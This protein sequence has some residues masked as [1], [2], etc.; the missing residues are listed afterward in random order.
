LN[1]Y[2]YRSFNVLQ[3]VCAADA[4]SNRKRNSPE[5]NSGRIDADASNV[6]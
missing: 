4:D 3:A 2:E 5:I 1:T 6:S